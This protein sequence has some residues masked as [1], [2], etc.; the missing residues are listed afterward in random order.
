M[1]LRDDMAEKK[2]P[3]KSL[4]SAEKLLHATLTVLRDAGGELPGREVIARVEKV[5]ELT[6][7]ERLS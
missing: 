7:W 3:P 6:P 5:V 4:V 1:D 2:D